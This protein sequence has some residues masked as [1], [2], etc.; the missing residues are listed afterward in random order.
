MSLHY[1][2]TLHFD[3]KCLLNT[4]RCLSAQKESKNNHDFIYK[5]EIEVN[6]AV[7]LEAPEAASSLNATLL[8]HLST[9]S[10]LLKICMLISLLCPKYK[11]ML[12]CDKNLEFNAMSSSEME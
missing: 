2:N 7:S 9:F 11:I 1:L 6:I 12:Y 4:R 3:H 10:T 8:K 5:Q